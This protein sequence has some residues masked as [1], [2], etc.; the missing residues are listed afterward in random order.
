MPPPATGRKGETFVGGARSC[1]TRRVA[2]TDQEKQ[3]V[4]LIVLLVPAIAL[5]VIANTI[6]DP[7]WLRLTLLIV[8]VVFML[9]IAL[10]LLRDV[11][12]RTSG[13]G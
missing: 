9:V 11:R 3:A 10:L 4:V 8:S 13:R 2:K 1:Y 7:Q 12:R 5:N 6:S